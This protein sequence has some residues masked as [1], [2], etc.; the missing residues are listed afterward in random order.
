VHIS[1]YCTSQVRDSA[2]SA[3]LSL[4]AVP[5]T[6]CHPRKSHVLVGGLGGFGLELAQWLVER[7]ARYLVLTSPGGVRTGYQDRCVRRWRQ[8]GVAVTVST[9]DVTNVDETRSLL[10]GA[11][12]MCPDGVGSVF[13]LAAI[14]RDGLVVNQTAADWSWST[15]PKVSQSISFLQF[16]LQCN[17]ETAGYED[18]VA[19][20]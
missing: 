19:C 8:A 16:S 12:S 4:S 11:A 13:N 3:Y 6:A 1:A 7:G 15:K 14:L 9:A 10:L 17:V 2:E 20:R 5:R 18:S